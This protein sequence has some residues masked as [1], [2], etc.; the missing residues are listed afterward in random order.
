MAGADGPIYSPAAF[1]EMMLPPLTWLMKELAALDVHY[2]FRTD[3]SSGPSPTCFPR[4]AMPGYGEVD[5]DATMTVGALR[6]RYPELVLWT[7][8]SS[9][10]I[11]T[12]SAA[13]VRED[14]RRCIQESGGTRY[15]HGA[16]NAI[17]KGTPVENVRAMFD[18][19]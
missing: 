3:G 5:R 15:F 1:R 18:T 7:N 2:M 16:S 6:Q 10:R 14:S 13:W 9:S 4:G 12:E 17:L 19:L 8:M 11:A